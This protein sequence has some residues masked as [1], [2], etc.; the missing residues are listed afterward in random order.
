LN[1]GVLI[2]AGMD[3]IDFTGPFEV[4]SRIPGAKI[5]VIAKARTPIRDFH[6]LILTPEVVL[7]E[8]PPWTCCMCP[9]VP[10]SRI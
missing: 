5:H 4:F 2:F 8:A 7:A 6:R 3:Q 1:I 10:D 9:A